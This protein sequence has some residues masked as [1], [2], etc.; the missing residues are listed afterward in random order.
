MSGIPFPKGQSLC[1]RHATQITSR[2]SKDEFVDIR[3]IPGRHVLEEHRKH[4]ESF[5][6]HVNSSLEFRT[7]FVDILKK[8][9]EALIAL[10]NFAS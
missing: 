4:V 10:I 7:Q 9:S 3:I 2:R 5:H 6:V 8:V 1:T